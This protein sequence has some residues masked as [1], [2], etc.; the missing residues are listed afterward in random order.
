MAKLSVE[1]SL[2]VKIPNQEFGMFK[3]ATWFGDI[4]A[5]GDVEAQV[6]KLSEAFETV[7]QGAE[8]A[9]AQEA[10]NVSGLS[11]EG[12]GLAGEFAEYREYTQKVRYRFIPF[13]F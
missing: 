7:A 5:D 13:V 4:D 6:A 9:L 1:L 3:V 11:V 8:K 10:A 12:L 2:T